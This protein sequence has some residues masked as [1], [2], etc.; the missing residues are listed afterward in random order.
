M[1]LDAAQA[2]GAPV[3]LIQPEN[4]FNTTPTHEISRLL[5]ESDKPFEAKIFL[6]WGVNAPEAHRFTTLG[7]QVWEPHVQRLLERHL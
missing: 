4:N 2:V 3:M 7:A 5:E 6:S 1:I